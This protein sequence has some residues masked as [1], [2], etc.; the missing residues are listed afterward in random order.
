MFRRLEV[1]VNMNIVPQVV[2]R[3]DYLQQ[4]AEDKEEMPVGYRPQFVDDNVSTIGHGQ[5]TAG[6]V[7]LSA[8]LDYLQVA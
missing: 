2:E 6:R 5:W 3:S 8:R 7:N 4:V 1:G